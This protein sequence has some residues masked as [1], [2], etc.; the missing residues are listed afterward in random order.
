SAD[1]VGRA[2]LAISA[3]GDESR[4]LVYGEDGA[5]RVVDV[6]GLVAPEHAPGYFDPALRPTS[7]SPDATHLA[8][9]QPHELVVVDLADG[10]SRRFQVGTRFNVD[11]T[12]ADAS[13]VLVSGAPSRAGG[14]AQSWLVDLTNGTV[15]A[16]AYRPWTAFLG[17][18]TLTWRNGPLHW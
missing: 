5:W 8:L 12:W 10:T 17:D 18:T 9:P 2:A 7:L 1:P 4:V 11:V 15:H 14:P 6:P 16:S 13:H 3:P